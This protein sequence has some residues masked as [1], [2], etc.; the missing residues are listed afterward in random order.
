MVNN[1]R[2]FIHI[3]YMVKRVTFSIEIVIGSSLVK[4]IGSNLGID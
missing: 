1:K 3:K 4:D 2:R